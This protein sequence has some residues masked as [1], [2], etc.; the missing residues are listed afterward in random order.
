MAQLL[1]LLL[2]LAFGAPR[3]AAHRPLLTGPV[4]GAAHS[5]WEAA[6][7]VPWVTSSWSVKRVVECDAPVLWLKFTAE[8]ANQDVHLTAGTPAVPGLAATR[9]ALALFGPGLPPYNASSLGFAAPPPKP[10]QGLIRVGSPADQSNCKFLENTVS[11]RSYKPA[12]FSGV[13]AR[14]G[15]Y[16]PYSKAYLWITA[17]ANVTLPVKG[18]TY[19]LAAFLDGRK[20]TGR[21]TVAIANWAEDEDFKRPYQ[22]P[23]GNRE[24]VNWTD[25]A[26]TPPAACCAGGKAAVLP[27]KAGAAKAAW[28]AAGDVRYCPPFNAFGC[29]PQPKDRAL[30][31]ANAEV[32]AVSPAAAAK[33]LKEGWAYLE[34]RPALAL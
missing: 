32:P 7:Q 23:K 2:I 16:E 8:R 29:G 33:L 19:Y 5:T 31:A 30:Q 27:A 13:G 4:G 20:S 34:M 28:Q 6:L 18:G 15:Y 21:F 1:P 10:G 24:S 14:C 12:N 25:A 17:D 9:P 22:A 11:K 3:A 26:A